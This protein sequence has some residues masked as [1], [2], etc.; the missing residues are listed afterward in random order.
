MEA[1]YGGGNNRMIFFKKMMVL[2]IFCMFIGGSVVPAL[3]ITTRYICLSGPVENI[4]ENK[5]WTIMFY[6]DSD[7]FMGYHPF[8]N[9]ANHAFSADNLSV[10]VLEDK[11]LNPA[12]LWSIDSFHNP[13]KLESLGEINMGASS[14]LQDFVVYCKQQ[15]P[16]D[17]YVL[18]VYDHGMGWA[19]SCID[20]SAPAQLVRD[21]LSMDEMQ[22]ALSNAGG[23]DIL[24]FTAP[25]N[26][27]AVESVYE[28]RDCVD[29]YIGS[30][31]SS[32]FI[33][34]PDTI[35]TLCE[36]LN[37]NPDVSN[38]ELGVSVVDWIERD[39]IANESYGDY[40]SMSAVRT[41]KITD[42]V[43]K[44]DALSTYIYN[45]FNE[46]ISVLNI[47]H[48]MSKRVGEYYNGID[49]YDFA[50][51]YYEIEQNNL[52]QNHLQTIMD[53]FNEAVINECHAINHSGDNGLSIYFPSNTSS[54]NTGYSK[55]KLDFAED[56]CWDEL[57]KKNT[58]KESISFFSAVNML[59]FL[60]QYPLFFLFR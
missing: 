50:Q 44:I 18:T 22:N 33:Y 31:E 38:T 46:S 40:L 34:W 57:L 53:S 29:I 23:V 56:T 12:A 28:L 42:L 10:V 11:W 52:I 17:R 7:F 49:L 25:C 4:I 48:S 43:E 35:K 32:G 60:N 51:H 39:A 54:Y 8:Y 27:G 41:D 26:M 3:S 58:K 1:D 16:A 36:T 15:Y 55:V 47:A 2:S 37:K 45:N 30:E 14:T 6:D 19:G 21:F 24:C 20:I 13:T 5:K 59:F 9:F